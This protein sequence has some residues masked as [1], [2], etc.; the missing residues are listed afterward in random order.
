MMN[1]RDYAAAI[2]DMDGTLIASEI[3][4]LQSWRDAARELGR[5]M[6][7]AL[8]AQMLGWNEPDTIAGLAEI[9]A[10]RADAEQFIRSA[11]RHYRRIARESGHV[12]RPGVLELIDTLGRRGLKLAVATSTARQLAIETLDVAGLL[13]HF[14][15][16]VGG[17]EIRRGK[18]DPEIFLLAASRL[19]VDPA[20]C[21]VFEDSQAGTRAAATAGMDV[22]LVPEILAPSTPTPHAWRTF[23]SHHEALTLF[24]SPR[25]SSEQSNA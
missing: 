18:P 17:D 10:S 16:V 24:N 20:A 9:W 22:I 2:F 12:V 8:Y 15:V 21:V 7:D 6:T 19:G 25:K 4:Y 1:A 13:A 5:P 14:P 23:N 3:Y 11:D